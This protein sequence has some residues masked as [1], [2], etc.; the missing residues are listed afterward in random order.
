MVAHF[1]TQPL[2]CFV[3]CDFANREIILRTISDL[4]ELATVLESTHELNL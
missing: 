2:C 3:D 1:K 4:S